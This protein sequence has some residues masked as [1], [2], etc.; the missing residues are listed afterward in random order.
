M[1]NLNLK[2]ALNPLPP[3]L[4]TVVGF[5]AILWLTLAP[6]PLGEEELPLFPGADKIAHLVMFGGFTL[7]MLV[8][9]WRR[10]RFSRLSTANIWLAGTLSAIL[11][12]VVEVAQ[13]K[14]NLGRSFEWADIIADSLG[15]FG[16]SLL[17]MWLAP[18]FLD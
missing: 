3:F 5:L 10:R 4:L 16:C 12:C 11:G 6:H 1:S 8:D 14:M 15:A 7:L 13:W 2:H 17:W 18:K 9:L